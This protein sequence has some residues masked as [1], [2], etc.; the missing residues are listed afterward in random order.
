MAGKEL[1]AAAEEERGDTHSLLQEEALLLETHS[2]VLK[3]VISAI[4]SGPWVTG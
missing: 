3:D 4:T 2:P 1:R